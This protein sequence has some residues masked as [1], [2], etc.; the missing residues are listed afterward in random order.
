MLGKM[1]IVV[2]YFP[3]GDVIQF[4]TNIL[5]FPIMTFSHMAKK[6]TTKIVNKYRKNEK[7]F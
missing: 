6:V 3:G 7:S 1:C 5:S 4:K 2:V